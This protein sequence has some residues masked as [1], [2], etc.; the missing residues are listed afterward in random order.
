M[1]RSVIGSAVAIARRRDLMAIGAIELA[2]AKL[3]RGHAPATVLNELTSEQDL[4]DAYQDGRLWVALVDDLPVGFALVTLIEEH[5]AHLQEMNVDPAHGRRGLGR[6]L[7]AA[8]FDWADLR[9]L[10]A[11]TLTTFRD[12][13]FNMP[14]YARMGFEEISRSELSPALAE[15]LRNETQRGLERRVAMRRYLKKVSV[16]HSSLS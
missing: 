5:C 7:V 16:N 10:E 15:V 2:A 14:F 12:V 6:S 9:G 3:L 8:V 4:L 11:V 1:N 13:A